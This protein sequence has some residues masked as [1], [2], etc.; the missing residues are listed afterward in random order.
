[1]TISRFDKEKKWFFSR[2][3]SFRRTSAL[4][5]GLGSL[6]IDGDAL[7]CQAPRIIE[8]SYLTPTQSFPTRSECVKLFLE[9]LKT[10]GFDRIKIVFFHSH[11]KWT[12]KLS[13]DA[14]GITS[15]AS[16]L[17]GCRAEDVAVF[18]SWSENREWL[19][20]VV[21]EHTSLVLTT[22]EDAY[23]EADTQFK[24]I[25]DVC[26]VSKVQVSLLEGA[27]LG[28][29]SFESFLIDPVKTIF[30]SFLKLQLA[31]EAE[32]IQQQPAPQANGQPGNPV[33]MHEIKNPK[34]RGLL[35]VSGDLAVTKAAKPKPPK[36]VKVEEV[37]EDDWENLAD[38]VDEAAE[39]EPIE[40]IEPTV[41]TINPYA[42]SNYTWDMG[43]ADKL[44]EEKKTTTQEIR[45]INKQKYFRFM[46]KYAESLESL[47]HLHHK[48]IISK[49]PKNEKTQVKL[50]KKAQEIIKNQEMASQKKE[51]EQDN[52]FFKKLEESI[53][54]F[55]DIDKGLKDIDMSKFQTRF[56]AD[57]TKLRIKWMK[58][59]SALYPDRKANLFLLINQ[60]FDE[61]DAY[62]TNEEAVK[63]LGILQKLD[64]GCTAEHLCA[65]FNSSKTKSFKES[66]KL[67]SLEQDTKNEEILFQ[68]TSMGDKLKRTLNSEPDSRVKFKPDMW[69]RKLLD[70]VD[71]RESALVCCPTSSGKTFISYYAMEQSLRANDDDMVVFV[72]PYEA[73]ANQIAAEVYAR[74][75]SKTYPSYSSKSVYAMLMP[76]YQINDI[77]NCQILITMPNSF[78]ALLSEKTDVVK[79]IKY[80]I[81]D[82]IH[83]LSDRESGRSIEKIIH[84]AQ[85][86]IVALSA[87]I[88]NLDPFYDWMQSVSQSK[89]I[90]TH[91]IVH[92]ERFCDLKKHIF[93]PQSLVD[94]HNRN[95]P[96]NN[97]RG[98]EVEAIDS[99]SEINELFG[100]SEPYLRS[101]ELSKDFHLLPDE[102]VDVLN[103]IR[104]LAKTAE[105]KELVKSI[106]PASFFKSVVI[107]KKEVKNY[108]SHL[109][110]S[111]RE[112]YRLGHFSKQEIEEFFRSINRKCEK[113]FE[114]VDNEY[115]NEFSSPKWSEDN[116]ME[117]IETL[118]KKKLLPAI[119]FFK[120][121]DQCDAMA[122]KLVEMLMEREEAFKKSHQKD[123]S[124][125]EL[126]E[127]EKLR[128]VKL[129]EKADKD[130]TTE[131]LIELSNLRAELADLSKDPDLVDERFTFLDPKFKVSNKEIDDLSSRTYEKSYKQRVVQQWKRGIGLHHP[132]LKKRYRQISEMLF[133]KKHVQIIFATESLACGIN[134]PCKTVILSHEL[135]NYDSVIYRH[136][137]GRAGRRGYDTIGHVVYFGLPKQKIQNFISSKTSDISGVAIFDPRLAM[138]MSV[139]Q[140][141]NPSAFD[142]MSSIVNNP[143][144]KLNKASYDKGLVQEMLRLQVNYLVD[145]GFMDELFR[146]DKSVDLA[147]PARHDDV[148]IEIIAELIKDGFFESLREYRNKNLAELSDKIILVLCHLVSV[149]LILPSQSR[150]MTT[151]KANQLKFKLPD[152]P[153]LERYLEGK[154][155][156]IDS[157]L[158]LNSASLTRACQDFCL[159]LSRSFP[160]YLAQVKLPK[161]SAIYDLYLNGELRETTANCHQSVTSLWY[162]I[163]EVKRV[164]KV[165]VAY[166][167]KQ[168]DSLLKSALENCHAKICKRHE[169]F[170]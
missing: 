83:M 98:Q 35:N 39:E 164:L 165:L 104:R 154:R 70:I 44:E 22:E 45:M 121:S 43:L 155:Q 85:C 1:M 66:V 21:N 75:S 82:E 123:P 29:S 86:P 72:S 151:A 119:M 122:A 89:G 130:K 147:L 112:W 68:L 28:L 67:K 3:V 141:Y 110:S 150:L 15:E 159:V 34:L 60:I 62:L 77:D 73:L 6:I 95:D 56:F 52:V 139:M 111:L 30:S 169:L 163:D 69:Q 125:L 13:I 93:V 124:E 148:P 118:Q 81:L 108:E 105:Q 25:Y 146:A 101:Y 55:D 2:H 80:I 97:Q 20:F 106:Q 27:V 84:F 65:K 100:Y 133:R 61:Y 7:I 42:Y 166:Q 168:G 103:T 149:S 88:G 26:Q 161:N 9:Q 114:F 91:K 160:V 50:G 24:F 57:L 167:G 38:Q 33:R 59:E 19:D 152:V 143:L 90:R 116:I 102:I 136:T 107:D 17:I 47:K 10:T 31:E 16:K 71:K 144:I 132:N 51:E 14:F 96:N 78:E 158:K 127:K 53:S 79:K 117:L 142:F 87:T 129:L 128:I 170:D 58:N 12:E 120:S 41:A 134:M 5:A 94:K 135:V 40:K 36:P 8:N 46:E 156:R 11:S 49:T 63:F 32:A 74:F 64:L 109:M 115:G 140:S 157:Y 131:G 162:S 126:V 48:I 113:I 138:Q 37:V 153:E 4:F 145:N 76:D 18:E 23:Q 92:T 137:I 99:L 54:C